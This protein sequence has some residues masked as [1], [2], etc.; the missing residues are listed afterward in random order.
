MK[1]KKKKKK[2]KR[3]G[4]K[5]PRRRFHQSPMGGPRMEG[6]TDKG[7]KKRG[8]L[9]MPVMLSLSVNRGDRMGNEGGKKERKGKRGKSDV[10]RCRSSRK[11]D[12]LRCL[13]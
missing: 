5:D 12:Q 7:K 9:W 1:K 4:R 8:P 2:E 3:R 13:R 11:G 6:G 10:Q